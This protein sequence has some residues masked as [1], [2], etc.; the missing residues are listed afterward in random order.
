ML[1]LNVGKILCNK[2]TFVPPLH[3]TRK[4]AQ[5]LYTKGCFLMQRIYSFLLCDKNVV[6]PVDYVYMRNVHLEVSLHKR[7]S[8]LWRHCL[9]NMRDRCHEYEGLNSESNLW[10]GGE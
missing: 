4:S 6:G 2:Y 9:M 3:N 8:V 10:F 1:F 7:G 5:S